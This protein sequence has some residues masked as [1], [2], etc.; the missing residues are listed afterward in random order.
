MAGKK[1]VNTQQIR[2]ITSQPNTPSP[3]LKFP[4]A[5]SAETPSKKTLTQSVS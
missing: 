4:H 1:A 2:R 3:S 5:S